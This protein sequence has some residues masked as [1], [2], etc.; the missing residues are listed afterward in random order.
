MNGAGDLTF[1]LAHQQHQFMLAQR[2]IVKGIQG[3]EGGHYAGGAGA[4]ARAYRHVFFQ[5][6]HQRLGANA[7]L[8]QRFF[9]GQIAVVDDILFEIVRQL[10]GKGAGLAQ[11]KV[12]LGVGYQYPVTQ[13]GA[14]QRGH[15]GPQ[16]IKAHAH[17][18]GRGRGK[19]N[20]TH[21]NLLLP[22]MGA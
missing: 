14:V 11:R 7:L 13:Q 19:R 17:I 12:T 1:Q 20:N 3:H 4:E 22:V 6:H 18:G 5:R 15:G 21:L 16:Y 8:R 10:V 9:I 2:F